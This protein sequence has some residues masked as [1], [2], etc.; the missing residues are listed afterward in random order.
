ML[1]MAPPIFRLLPLV[2]LNKLFY[3]SIIS[4]V[5]TGQRSFL[6]PRALRLIRLI[7]SIRS[8]PGW[9]GPEGWTRNRRAGGYVEPSRASLNLESLCQPG[10]FPSAELP[11]CC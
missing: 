3:K 8:T 2:E 5:R 1:R 11:R 7:R 4:E 9:K 10:F 6:R